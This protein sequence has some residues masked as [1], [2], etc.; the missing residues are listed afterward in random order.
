MEQ[1]AEIVFLTSK[2]AVDMGENEL[3]VEHHQFS[4]KRHLVNMNA[5]N[6]YLFVRDLQNRDFKKN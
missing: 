3:V 4:T 1:K 6:R 5:K 2:T